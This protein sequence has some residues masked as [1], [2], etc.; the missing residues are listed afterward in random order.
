MERGWRWATAALLGVGAMWLV[1]CATGAGSGSSVEAVREL[2]LER[3]AG[4]WYEVASVPL[5]AQRGC[6]GTTATYTLREDGDVKVENRCFRDSFEGRESGI[7]GRAW[8]AGE[9]EAGKL[10]V[11]FFWPLR[12]AYWVVALD[13][14]YRWAAV[15]G[16]ERKNLWIL[17]REPCMAQDAFEAIVRDLQARGF[18]VERLRATPQR[19]AHGERCV[20]SL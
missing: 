4:R 10:Y 12:S 17:S 7:T 11:R 6:V 9:A 13:P 8:S 18:P 1:S 3:Y 19:D 16:P 5:R 15:S 20:V 14:G 2:D